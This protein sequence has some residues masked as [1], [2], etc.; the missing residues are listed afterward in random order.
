MKV[1][2][3]FR[4]IQGESRFSGLPCTF[5]RFTGCNLRCHYCDTPDAFYDGKD[6]TLEDVIKEITGLTTGGGRRE[7]NYRTQRTGIIKGSSLVEITG[8]EP[9]LQEEIYPLVTKLLDLNYTVL[10]ETNGSLD[11]GRLDRRA[12]RIMD[13]KTPS[14]GMAERMDFKNIKKLNNK[15]EIKFVISD[16]DD[17]EWSKDVLRRYRLPCTVLFSPTHGILDPDIISE[18]IL[19]DNLNV[20]LNLQLHKYIWWD[21]KE[22]SKS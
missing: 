13:I 6:M 20:R 22:S 9:L 17:Y 14:S 10:I 15:D 3:I 1:N 12:I 7:T 18:W 21:K 11:I 4:S 19:Q 16:R 5:I 8:G 2:E